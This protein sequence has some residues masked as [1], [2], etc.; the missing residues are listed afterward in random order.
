VRPRTMSI[1]CQHCEGIGAC[2]VGDHAPCEGMAVRLEVWLRAACLLQLRRVHTAANLT[3]VGTPAPCFGTRRRHR[4]VTRGGW[5]GWPRNWR[6]WRYWWRF[7]PWWWCGGG[8]GRVRR[9]AMASGAGA[10]LVATPATHR[11]C[12]SSASCTS[13]FNAG[14]VRVE[15]GMEKLGE[16]TGKRRRRGTLTTSQ[17]AAV[18]PLPRFSATALSR[19]HPPQAVGPTTVHHPP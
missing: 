10:L 12:V 8:N 1:H 2:M 16:G 17:S 18:P 9:R 4:H 15:Q 7:D 19:P 13:Q 14:F 3:L 6:R 5:G 11:T